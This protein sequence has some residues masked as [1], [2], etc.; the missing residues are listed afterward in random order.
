MDSQGCSKCSCWNIYSYA[1]GKISSSGNTGRLV[2]SKLLSILHYYSVVEK[3][4]SDT[5]FKSQFYKYYSK[6]GH[7]SQLFHPILCEWYSKIICGP[8][9]IYHISYHSD[10]SLKVRRRS[11]RRGINTFNSC[12][13][14]CWYGNMHFSLIT[15]FYF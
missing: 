5:D 1:V 13:L 4:L 7:T 8:Q 10:I 2:L 14:G 11:G 9:I 12:S 3:S 15:L 6:S